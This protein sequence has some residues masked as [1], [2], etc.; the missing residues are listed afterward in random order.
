[1]KTTETGEFKDF[2]VNTWLGHLS[3]PQS[4]RDAVSVGGK[5]YR[6]LLENV[7]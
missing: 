4:S 5:S 7:E 6:S 3:V 1:M 2:K